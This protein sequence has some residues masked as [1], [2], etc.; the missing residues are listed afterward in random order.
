MFSDVRDARLQLIQ[1]TR[2]AFFEFY[3]IARELEI[4]RGNLQLTREF[5]D[6]ARTKYENN[7]VTEQDVLQADVELPRPSGVCSNSNA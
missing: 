7:L 1:T 5:R 4:N 3:L 2:M 6:T